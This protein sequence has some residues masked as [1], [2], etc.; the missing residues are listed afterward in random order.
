MPLTFDVASSPPRKHTRPSRNASK[1][2]K[3]QPKGKDQSKDNGKGKGK[4]KGQIVSGITPK[5][6]RKVALK[7]TGRDSPGS[8]AKADDDDTND[9]PEDLAET[10]Y[11]VAA[12]ALISPT[13]SMLPETALAL[14]LLP[15]LVDEPSK[16]PIPGASPMKARSPALSPALSQSQ[17]HSQ[18]QAQLQ[19]QSLTQSTLPSLSQPFSQSHAPSQTQNSDVPLDSQTAA[20]SPFRKQPS[21][22]SLAGMESDADVDPDVNVE[23]EHDDDAD[24]SVDESIFPPNGSNIASLVPGHSPGKSTG[25]GGQTV[26]PA[27]TL[28]LNL[29]HGSPSS[30]PDKALRTASMSP[31]HVARVASGSGSIHGSP[32]PSG[33]LPRFPLWPPPGEAGISPTKPTKLGHQLLGAHGFN[34]VANANELPHTPALDPFPAFPALMGSTLGSAKSAHRHAKE[35]GVEVVRDLPDLPVP[36]P[37]HG[38]MNLNDANA[39]GLEGRDNDEDADGDIS[40]GSVN[41][42]PELEPDAVLPLPTALNDDELKTPEAE[43]DGELVPELALSA[44]RA[45]R[46]AK[47]DESVR[48][49]MEMFARGEAGEEV[50]EG[51]A[52]NEDED[53]G[54][55]QD[56]ALGE[57]AELMYLKEDGPITPRGGQDENED[58]P[59]ELD[60]AMNPDTPDLPQQEDEVTLPVA[61]EVMVSEVDA[62]E[63]A[64]VE[65]DDEPMR[66]GAVQP[67]SPVEMVA[68]PETN[69]FLAAIQD[70]TEQEQ[71]G[72]DLL[73]AAIAHEPLTAPVTPGA[74]ADDEKEYDGTEGIL[75][76]STAAP[77]ENGAVTLAAV[78]MTVAEDMQVEV[79]AST[80]VTTEVITEANMELPLDETM[81]PLL[82]PLSVD[83][84]PTPIVAPKAEPPASAGMATFGLVDYDSD[85]PSFSQMSQAP[86]EDLLAVPSMP[87][88]FSFDDPLVHNYPQPELSSQQAPL[89]ASDLHL[90]QR[91][92][93]GGAPPVAAAQ[94]AA[95]TINAKAAEAVVGSQVA[96]DNNLWGLADIDGAATESSSTMTAGDVLKS[97]VEEVEETLLTD[98]REGVMG[99]SSTIVDGATVG[100]T[101]VEDVQVETVVEVVPGRQT[102]AGV[103]EDD[104]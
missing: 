71:Q 9:E 6:Q 56:E 7:R 66:A 81:S 70:L 11:T 87:A 102:V 42:R 36:A 17:G 20:H 46:H 64:D 69:A 33:P 45:H 53:D 19:T 50:E 44:T 97:V 39:E 72:Q 67:N 35:L 15:V 10:D 43:D 90:L 104:A 31:S 40:M 8:A 83:Q 88:G 38:D 84:D 22:A 21:F 86:E 24:G 101:D 59:M 63:E 51:I 18:A 55:G 4:G 30:S 27:L 5:Y 2:L 28:N 16:R 3:A 26:S 74:L 99:F 49:L 89:T 77:S 75:G 94:Q 103:V 47:K 100:L 54:N 60:D 76:D 79:E 13:L 65:A 78:E 37:V 25:A 82:A 85:G 23:G 1:S 62:G 29:N 14:D 34:G 98:V 95:D 91:R 92:I 58:V 48:D 93:F 61:P 96:L 80:E 32:I 57:G 41:H 73:A 52:E 68:A 12:P